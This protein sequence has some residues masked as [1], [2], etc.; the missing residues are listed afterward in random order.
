MISGQK[1]S[2]CHICKICNNQQLVDLAAI[3]VHCCLRSSNSL[4][5]SL[6]LFQKKNILSVLFCITLAFIDQKHFF[7]NL[8]FFQMCSR[9][10]NYGQTWSLFLQTDH[11]AYYYLVPTYY[12]LV[13]LPFSIRAVKE[14][15]FSPAW[16]TSKWIIF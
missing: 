14:L 11:L 2:L 10:Q 4:Y 8:Y 13:P 16:E 1:G 15:Q 7:L 9:D 3:N 5:F 6:K 12:Y